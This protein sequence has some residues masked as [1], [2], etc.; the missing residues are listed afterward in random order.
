MS[1]ANLP[2]KKGS[3]GK[4]DG[5]GRPE[6]SNNTLRYGEVKAIR[7]ANLRL[8]EGA[9]EESHELA[10][11]ALQRI[12]DVMECRVSHLHAGNVLKAATRL[13]EEVCGPV[14]QKLEHSGANGGPITHQL[15]ILPPKED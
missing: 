14:A 15:V 7:A 12:A 3:G 8:P 10:G 2:R 4:R 5:A 6:G 9:D 13:R 11:R 1:N